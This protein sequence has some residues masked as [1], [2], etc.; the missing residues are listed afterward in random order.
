MRGPCNSARWSV[1]L[2]LV[3][4]YYTYNSCPFFSTR[5]LARLL[6]P[7]PTSFA[8][9]FHLIFCIKHFLYCISFEQTLGMYLLKRSSNTFTRYMQIQN[10]F[11][12]WQRGEQVNCQSLETLVDRSYPIAWCA[13]DFR[14]EVYR[15]EAPLLGIVFHRGCL[16]SDFRALQSEALQEVWKGDKGNYIGHV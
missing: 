6:H 16:A 2:Y 8:S 11:R 7:N 13:R 9:L 15:K 5:G 10:S 4:Y 1:T 14:M 12:L 3:L